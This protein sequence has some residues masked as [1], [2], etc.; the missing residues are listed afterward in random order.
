[1]IVWQGVVNIE[2]HL[3]LRE[4]LRREV[5]DGIQELPGFWLE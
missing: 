3:E 4:S 5:I 1:M 2:N